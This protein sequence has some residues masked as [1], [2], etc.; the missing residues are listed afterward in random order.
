MQVSIVFS[1]P[2]GEPPDEEMMCNYQVIATNLDELEPDCQER[3]V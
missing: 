3:F 2:V 1:K